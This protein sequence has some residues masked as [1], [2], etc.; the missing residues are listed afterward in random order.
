MAVVNVDGSSQLSVDITAQL[1]WLSH[2]V[3]K[4]GVHLALS[5]KSSNEPGEFSE[6]WCGYLSEARC[7]LFA[8]GP[9]DATEFQNPHHL[10]SLLSKR[11]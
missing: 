4:L 3:S 7:R 1:S 8:Y 9:A 6:C 10:L 11:Q 5:L 2:R